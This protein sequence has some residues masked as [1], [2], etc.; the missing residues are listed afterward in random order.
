MGTDAIIIQKPEGAAAQLILLLHGY[1]SNARDLVPTGQAVAN[2]FPKALVVSVNA[3]EKSPFADGFQW[4]GAEDLTEENRQHRV[5]SAMPSFANCIAHWQQEA[6]LDAQGTAIIGFSQGAIMALESTKLA[7]PPAQ[8]V[9][10]IA[11]R[12]ATLPDPANF[13]GTVH[14]LH[15]KEDAVIAYQHTVA[16]AHHLRD[17]G[18]DITAEV[19]PF[20]GHEIA[21]DFVELIA[22]KLS[23]H[24]SHRVW[25]QAVQNAEP[26]HT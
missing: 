23:T 12:F 21:P 16:A 15:G 11:G 18:V 9:V 17:S 4:F 2:E 5:N 20:V 6:G 26:D 3:P 7:R 1:G 10:S 24:I 8:R 25:N 22:R 14:F 19:I 13:E